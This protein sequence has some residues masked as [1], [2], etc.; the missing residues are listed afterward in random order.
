MNKT[1]K[2][3]S[4]HGNCT[5]GDTG[6]VLA[7]QLDADFGLLPVYVNIPEWQQRYPGEEPWGS[8]HDILD[9]GF[10]D[11]AGEYSEP[12]ESWRRELEEERLVTANT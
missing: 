4:S 2:L 7:C 6:V 11:S 12:C 10:I 8:D 5:V 3:T 9:F 1:F